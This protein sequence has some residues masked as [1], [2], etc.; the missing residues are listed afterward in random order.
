MISPTTYLTEFSGETICP[1]GQIS[2]LVKIGDQGHFTYAWMNFM[3]VRSPSQHNGIIG[4]PGIR[5]IRAIPSMA[6]GM[7]KFPV[8]GGTVTLRSNRIIRME[9]AMISG[10]STRPPEAGKILEEKIR[11]A[12]HPEYPEQTIA[13][14][15]TLTEK[16]RMLTCQTKEKRANTGKKQSNPRRS[17]KTGGCWDHEG[18]SLPQLAIQP[19]NGQEA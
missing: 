16:G 14:G 13:I 18:S 7:L 9:C 15:S 19:G 17:G 11:V 1:L 3:V 12:I 6:H 2:L 10:P 4:R 8:E 5:K